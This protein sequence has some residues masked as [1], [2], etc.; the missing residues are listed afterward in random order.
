VYA[1]GFSILDFPSQNEPSLKAEEDVSR[2]PIVIRASRWSLRC[3]IRLAT[4][5][6]SKVSLVS[7][8]GLKLGSFITMSVD[9]WKTK[10]A[11]S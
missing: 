4:F 5:G 3:Q 11:V 2:R 9:S 1:D 8:V 10:T 6:H 7:R